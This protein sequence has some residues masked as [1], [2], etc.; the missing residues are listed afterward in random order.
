MIE[1]IVIFGLLILGMP[2]F[3]LYLMIS[4]KQEANR[5]LG[6]IVLILG[7]IVWAFFKS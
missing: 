4:K 7:L 3:G 5:G 1:A 2:F 6:V